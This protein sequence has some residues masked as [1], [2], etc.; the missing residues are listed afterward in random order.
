MH[1]EFDFNREKTKL[2]VSYWRE[3]IHRFALEYLGLKLHLFQ[4]ILLY[5]MD[6]YPFFMWIAIRGG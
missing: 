3:N 4:L 5:L 6:K 1:Q 2:W